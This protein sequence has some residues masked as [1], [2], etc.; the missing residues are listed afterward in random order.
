MSREARA[1]ALP[2]SQHVFAFE[3]ADSN[4]PSGRREFK[5]A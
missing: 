3:S 4:E 1:S 5:R 2:L